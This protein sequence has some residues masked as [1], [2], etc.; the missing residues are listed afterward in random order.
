LTFDQIAEPESYDWSSRVRTARLNDIVLW[1]QAN[2]AVLAT[3]ID[4]IEARTHGDA[5]DVLSISFTTV[6]GSSGDRA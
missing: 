5:H 2:G 3:K 6:R 1:R 4:R